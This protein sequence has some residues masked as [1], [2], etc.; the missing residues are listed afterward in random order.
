MQKYQQIMSDLISQMENEFITVGTK[1]PSIREL[2][3]Q[4]GCSTET[5]L[6]ALHELK[7]QHRIFSVPKKGFYVLSAPNHLSSTG[8]TMIDLATATPE[9]S[10]FP[11]TEFQ[12]CLNQAIEIQQSGLFSYGMTVNGLPSLVQE[13]KKKLEDYQIFANESE[14]VITT[15]TQQALYILAQISFPNQSDTILIEQPTYHLFNQLV[16]TTGLK[17][18]GIRRDKNGIDLNDLEQIFAKYQIKFFY[19]IPRF[20]NPLGTS[21]TKKEK[22]AILDLA[23]KYNVYIVEDDYLADFEVDKKVDPMFAY[24]INERVIY[25]KSFSK[26]IFPGLRIGV[27][28]LPSKILHPFKSLKRVIDYDTNL[29]T[30]GALELYLKSGMFDSH[31]AKLSLRYA[32]KSNIL[33]QEIDLQLKICPVSID[34]VKPTSLDT[35]THLS[36]P[37]RINAMELIRHMKIEKVLLREIG[38]NYL[39]NF[40]KENILKID[41]RNTNKQDIQ[42]GIQ[43]LFQ[44]IGRMG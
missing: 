31:S 44:M 10:M 38:E 36:L 26:I 43:K 14:I 23:Q 2:K 8:T 41:V 6:K 4:Y 40:P 27:I 28:V 7:Y 11:Y 39:S 18:M 22:L 37:R 13:I 3:N 5:V 21:Y 9:H 42:T 1:L 30:Q 35:K 20:H 33:H 25:V 16:E 34:Y 24:D 32:E 12:H 15:G 19:T 17:C 29:V